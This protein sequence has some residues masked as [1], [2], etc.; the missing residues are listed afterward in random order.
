[1]KPSLL[2]S[3]VLCLF[4]AASFPLRTS[5]APAPAPEYP[6]PVLAEN[7]DAA[8]FAEWADGKET[9][10]SARGDKAP[11][12]DKLIW[13]HQSGI[14]FQFKPYGDSKTP[15][16]RYLRIGFNAPVA[17]GSILVQGEGLVSVL[18]PEATYPGD[19][20]DDSQWIPAQRLKAGAVATEEPD[21]KAQTL[22]V[23][24]SV[25]STR[26]VRFTHIAEPTDRIYA[27]KLGGVFLL[28][29][30]L[31][32]LA[33][34]ALAATHSTPKLAGRLND[35]TY[36]S[37]DAWCNIPA[38]EG[39]RA[40]T[41]VEDP[42]WIILTW[43]HPVTLKGLATLG[44]GG[45]GFSAAEVQ[46]YTGP[47]TKHPKEASE[48]DWKT[49]QSIAGLKSHYPVALWPEW[50]TFD[51]PVTTRAVRVRLTAALDE[52]SFHGHLKGNTNNGKRVWLDEV[53][54]L[55]S[56]DQAELKTAI[57][58]PAIAAAG[59]EVHAPI[60]VKFTLPEESYVTLVV[61]DSKGIRVRNL[62]ADT[63]FKKGKNT[64]YWDG[65]DDLGRDLDAPKHGLYNIPSQFVAPGAYTVRGL[66]HGKL[67]VRYEFSVY[68]PGN[69]PW[70]TDDGSGGWMTNHTPAGCTLFIPGEKLPGGKPMMYIGS[71][72][73]EGGSALSWTDLDGNK[74]A[75]RG[76]IGG[77]WT[78]AQ[79]MA[80]DTGSNPIPDIIA[81]VGAAWK[82][83]TQKDKGEVRL[84]AL[85]G[86]NSNAD[87]RFNNGDKPVLKPVYTFDLAAMDSTA[88]VQGTNFLNPADCMGGLAVHD[89]LL[90]F[91]QPALNQLVFVDA[92][93]GQVIATAP[94]TSPAGLAF[95][96]QGRLLALSGKDILRFTV[97]VTKGTLG[98]PETVVTGL[99]EPKELT[100]DPQGNVYVS[101]RGNSHQVKVFAAD[102][103]P[104]KTY[105][106]PGAP[107][108]GIYDPDHMNNPKGI[109]VDSNGRL[110][111]AEEDFHPKRVSVWNTDGTLWKAFYGPQQY[112]GGGM[113]DAR[114]PVRF[115]Y[116]GM[117]FKLDWKKGEAP[118]ARVY[119]REEKNGFQMAARCAPPESPL[120]FN[121]HRY[122]T[123]VFNNNP[124]GGHGSAFV[125]LDKGDIAVPVAGIGRAT[126][127]EILKSDAF[128]SRWPEG[129]DLND[130]K[131]E[132][133]RAIFIWSDLNGDEQV[134]P[135]EVTLLP[136]N[137]G[138]ITMAQDGSFLVNNVRPPASK[139]PGQA[140]RFKPVRFT[141][142]GAP[143]Y[144]AK[145][146]V[147]AE[148]Q[149][150][151]SSGGDQ[152]LQGTDGWTVLTTPPRPYPTSALGGVKNGVP[153]WSYPSLWP[154]LHASHEAPTPDRPGELIGTTRLLG[155]FVTPKNSDAGPVFFIN[156]NMGNMYV[157]TQDGLFVTQLF[158]DVRQGP[159]WK[160][161]Q[162]QRGMRVNNLSL[163][164]E[165]FFPSVSQ[166]PDGNIYMMAGGT[167]ALVRVEG[168]ESIRRIAPMTVKVTPKDLQLAQDF[169][170]QREAARQAAQ[171]SGVIAVPL[172]AQAPAVDGNLKDWND[173][174]WAP[175][176]QR[177]VG[178][179][180]N[181]KSKP[182]DIRGAVAVAGGKLFAM[183]KT[184]DES[185]LKNS[186]AIDNAP[187]KT[188]GALDLMLGT[189][190]NAKPGRPQ[191]VAGDL[192]LLVTQVKGKTKA[193]LYRAVVPG[194]P[195]NR[196]VAFSAPW[197]SITMDSV[198]DVSAQVEFA[199]DGKGN[200][201]IAVP[202]A[203][204][205]LNPQ[206]GMKIKA[207][208]GVLRGNGVDT[209]QR[210]YWSN[211]ATAIVADVPSEAALT[212]ALW[213]TFEFHAQ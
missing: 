200:Y 33:P 209:T 67:D 73:S 16:A 213:G 102:G 78:G 187:F 128:K 157:L 201:E 181:S 6:T 195:P 38:R 87:W 123:N 51:Q 40:K 145:G 188:G 9:P 32:N 192:R 141:E 29:E 89:G 19:L 121:G 75:G 10:I 151:S 95:D 140:L 85:S 52:T 197:H 185:L 37:W 64:V 35:E 60:P 198:T 30:R 178:A 34:Q 208:I 20:N 184:E 194:T 164:D 204:L 147:I 203:L 167:P 26:A 113:L 84:T 55:Q 148:A 68:S 210:V 158:Q 82:G 17:V 171:G 96:A 186:G 176:D 120:Y 150:P 199:T 142:N 59:P 153:L 133:N 48:A 45:S 163:H 66:R 36:N 115:S 79:F 83:E 65:T 132:K 112:G 86:A 169:V 165:N 53:M 101:D 25:V 110:W 97:D 90:V 74:I 160:M 63:L 161:P 207:D 130:T 166:T 177:G 72:V 189:D 143:V 2:F 149:G 81:Y 15:G 190:P 12:A 118:L 91:S 41:I 131:S 205:G 42:E 58:P 5:A 43:P 124:T 114:D 76:W 103:K 39:E 7:L 46:I 175:I 138:G 71:Y 3:S 154:G 196:K 109:S 146:E 182:Y 159:L 135:D 4:A 18:K 47:K 193:V 136:G 144:D 202:L 94:L 126:D 24:P 56:L 180:F 155:D 92:K 54:A 139:E 28:S 183:W 105:G 23:L 49:V 99:E 8:A 104:L 172:R 206:P 88:K 108:A 22:W 119:Y 44:M 127:W 137:N 70:P 122:L 1:M 134:Q 13:T 50:I 174:D 69:P 125:F 156:S 106:K 111:V 62:V 173:A 57:I 212:P 77:N 117:E 107:K 11:T 61:E 168:M 21:E 211:K 80:R 152:L 116:D 93:A 27:G 170:T 98:T 100:L 191:P 129:I 31:A 162:A 14:G 179:N